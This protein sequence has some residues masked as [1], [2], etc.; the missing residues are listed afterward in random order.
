[1][2][3]ADVEQ[4]LVGAEVECLGQRGRRPGES[5]LDPGGGHLLEVIIELEDFSRRP[6]G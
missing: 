4:P 1:M 6:A 3:A 2:T 5:R